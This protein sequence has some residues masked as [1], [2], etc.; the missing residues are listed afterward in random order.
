MPGSYFAAQNLTV[1][2]V[3]FTSIFQIV[4]NVFFMTPFQLFIVVYVQ[5]FRWGKWYWYVFQKL[6]VCLYIF[7]ESPFGSFFSWNL[8]DWALLEILWLRR[9]P[10]IIRSIEKLF[11]TILGLKLSTFIL[12]SDP[13][14]QHLQGYVLLF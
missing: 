9:Q 2:T 11:S 8:Q 6:K 1:L 7:G 4:I 14:L 13:L 12:N 3:Y 5:F 10:W